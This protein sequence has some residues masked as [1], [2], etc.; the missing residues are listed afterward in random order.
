M[1]QSGGIFEATSLARA[2]EVS[3]PTVTAYAAVLEATHLAHLVRPFASGRATEIVSAPRVY[4]FDTGFVRHYRGWR[5]LRPEDLGVLWEHLVLNELHAH[6]GRG[7][8]RYWR[9]KHGSEVDFVVSA[10]G[11]P[12]AA[13]ECNW[14]ADQFDAAGIR[15]FRRSYPA[16]DNYVVAADVTEPFSRTIGGLPVRYVSLARLIS[17]LSGTVD[18]REPT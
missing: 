17:S 5:E 12:P 10:A 1:A 11:A 16:G 8:I 3:R 6:L 13:I 2:C 4:G 14:S 15:A 7:P 9:T 18:R